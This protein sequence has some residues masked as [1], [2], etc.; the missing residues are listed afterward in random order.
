MIYYG[1][2]N[3]KKLLILISG[4]FASSVVLATSLPNGSIAL[5]GGSILAIKQKVWRYH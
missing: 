5:S 1:E 4:L 2:I 3:M